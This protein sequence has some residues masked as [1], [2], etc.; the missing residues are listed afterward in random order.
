MY[1]NRE[2]EESPQSSAQSTC[3]LTQAK[4]KLS[5]S[6]MGY[7]GRTTEQDLA[8]AIQD[9]HSDIVLKVQAALEEQIA[10]LKRANE[11][12]SKEKDALD[13]KLR[14][15]ERTISEQRKSSKEMAYQQANQHYSLQSTIRK[16]AQAPE[17]QFNQFQSNQDEL[18]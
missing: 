10:K 9:I 11:E 14:S 13:K 15:A 8:S 6:K 17:F 4:V 1:N 5:K 3:I 2:L 12:L 18:P 16:V 7:L